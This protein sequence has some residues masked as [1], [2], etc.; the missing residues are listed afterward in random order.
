MSDRVRA[1][2]QGKEPP[3]RWV[4]QV[5]ALARIRWPHARL[6][7]AVVESV[8][9]AL[10]AQWQH[11]Q[12]PQQTARTLFSCDGRHIVAAPVEA[13]ALPAVRPPRN[14][15][16]G[17]V[18]GVEALRV[19]AQ[20]EKLRARLLRLDAKI[21][22]QES[23]GRAAQVKN[24]AKPSKAAATRLAKLD[25]DLKELQRQAAA[26][27]QELDEATRTPGASGAPRPNPRP[28]SGA[29][30]PPGLAACKLGL[31]GGACGLP[32]P[33]FLAAAQGAPVPRTARYCLTSAFRLIPSH[34]PGRGFAPHP[35]YPAEVQER[36]YDRDKGEQMKVI[37]IAQTL[38]PELVFHGAPGAIDGLPVVTSTGIVLGGNGRTMALQLHYAQGGSAPRKYL[39][40]HAREFGF[41]RAQVEAVPE[42]VIV[43]VIDTPEPDAPNY[44][45][46][47]RK[48]VRLLN[49]PLLKSLDVRAEAVAEARRL[50]D[51]ALEVLSVALTDDATLNAYLASADSR[52][53]QNTLRRAG[54]VNDRNAVRLLSTDGATF[55]EEGRR[56]VERLLLGALVPDAALL[57]RTDGRLREALARAAPWFLSAASGG[58]GWDLRLALRAA[59]VDL[60]TPALRET[61]VDQ[62]LRQTTLAEPPASPGVPLGESVLRLLD[63]I[64]TKPLVLARFAREFAA[65]S[66]QHP[67]AQGSLLPDEKRSP[68][69]AFAL[70]AA[71]I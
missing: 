51:E 29:S 2:R 8:W 37:S 54:I 49:V 27:R 1:S 43:R 33:L 4:A 68:A 20:A 28:R 22:L 21:R 45:P 25:A 42:P 17:E 53:F 38:L 18:F 31:T 40:E 23:K 46:E 64:G 14:A 66:R 60:A 16:P 24:T 15:Q 48:L 13:L 11:G 70:A 3:P 67:T 19:P 59:L 7:R 35:Q 41:T 47:L 56:F 34:L 55:S 26:V 6:D 63:E 30:C 52:A 57:D 32:A 65:A 61:S 12:T 71:R 5:L 39:L 10:R 62:F 50:P 9:A 58:E 36:A 69:Q 44:L